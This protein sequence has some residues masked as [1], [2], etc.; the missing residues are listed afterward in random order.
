MTPVAN[1][2]RWLAP[3]TS[4]RQC[5]SGPPISFISMLQAV[6]ER[7]DYRSRT[8]LIIARNHQRR[9]NGPQKPSRK[10]QTLFNIHIPNQNHRHRG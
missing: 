1:P 3:R 9:K 5:A 2:R 8:L 4:A 6:S 10:Y 7:Y